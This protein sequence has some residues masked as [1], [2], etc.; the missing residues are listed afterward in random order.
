MGS[1]KQSLFAFIAIDIDVNTLFYGRYGFGYLYQGGRLHTPH[2]EAK[3]RD[4]ARQSCE[5]QGHV[6]NMGRTRDDFTNLIILCAEEDKGCWMG[7][8]RG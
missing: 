7:R 8:F 3:R 4:E 1:Q 2:R 5:N 6:W